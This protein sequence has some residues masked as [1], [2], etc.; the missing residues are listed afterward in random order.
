MDINIR[1]IFCGL[2]VG[3]TEIKVTDLILERY[4][5]LGRG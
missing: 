4:Y 5:L 2:P 1:P 3:G